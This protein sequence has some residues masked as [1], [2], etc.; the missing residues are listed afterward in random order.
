[1]PWS[2]SFWEWLAYS[3]VLSLLILAFGSGAVLLCRQ[4]VRR[5]RIIELCLAGSLLAPFLGMIPGYPQWSLA[6]RHFAPPQRAAVSPLPE[7]MP[8]AEPAALRPTVVLRKSAVVQQEPAIVP[9]QTPHLTPQTVVA[10]VDTAAPAWDLGSLLVGLYLLGIAVGVAW[11]LVGTAA[12]VRI[13]W[14]ARAAPPR[15]RQLLREI[16]GRHGDRVRLLTS[17]LAK[18]PFATVGL[19][20]QLAP[21]HGAWC[22]AVIVLPESFCDDEQAVRWA[23]AHEW[24]HIERRDFQAWFVAGLARMLFFYQPLVWWLRCQLRLCQDY[25]ADARASREASQPEDYAEFLTVRA[26]AG[27]LHPAM[28]GLGMGFSKSELYRRVAMLVENRPLESRAPR[29][30]TVLVTC[31]AMVL[32]GAAAALTASPQAAAQGEAAAKRESTPATAGVSSPAKTGSNPQSKATLLEKLGLALTSS[33]QENDAELGKIIK[34]K[35]YKFLNSFDAPDGVKRY[36]YRLTY[37]DGRQVGR[38]FYVPLDKVSSLEEYR[39]KEKQQRHQ[40]QNRIERALAAGRFRLLNLEAMQMHIC[41]D[42]ASGKTFMVQRIRRPDQSEIALPRADFGPLPSAVKQTSWQE[43]LQ[44]IRDGKRQLLNL[45]ATNNYTYEITA[46]DGTKEILQYGGTEPLEA[47]LKRSAD[48]FSYSGVFRRMTPSTPAKPGTTEDVMMGPRPQGNCSLSGKL[49]SASTGKS[50]A[51]ARMYLFYFGTHASIFTNTDK[52]GAFVFKDIPTGP[53]YLSSIHRAGYQDARYN[54]EDKPGTLPDFQ[55]KDGEQRSGI[56][57]KAEDA[58]RIVGQIRDEDGNVPSDTRA[59]SVS[60]WIKADDS[61]KYSPNSRGFVKPDGS[62]VIDGLG[63]APVYVMA[64]NW[65]AE[66]EGNG[67]PPIYAP[68]AFFRGE[69]RLVTFDKS[70]SV[71]GVNIT[72]R[73]TGGLALEGIVRDEKGTPIPETLVVVH[74]RD[75]LFDRVTTYSDAQGRYQLQGLGDGEVLVHVDAIHRGFVRTRIPLA[76]E[77]NTPK[78]RRDFILHRGASISGKL[79]DQDG[80]EWQ[81]GSSHGQAAITGDS[82]EPKEDGSWSGP[83]SKYG[84]QGVGEGSAVFYMSGDGD[85]ERND[86]VF[87]TTSTF[88]FPSLKPGHTLITFSPQAEGKKVVKILHG[89]RDIMESGL[90]TKPGQEIKDVTIVIGPK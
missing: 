85:Y 20:V 56:V 55:L 22:R 26:A 13:I 64:R 38:S 36:V 41:R 1:M 72:L 76:L 58:C 63:N 39:Q 24:T 19:A 50:I 34:D 59:I 90:D 16:A 74:H 49:V 84:I 89:G 15:C 53:F 88:V 54:P 48:P 8:V 14:T 37:P 70:R 83:R 43:H 78:V 42:A 71:E 10:P 30:W 51:R 3:A 57:L 32:I 46:E 12:L 25:V 33:E 80:K 47:I 27:L 75:M 68:S 69:A 11:W 87:P 73:K 79:V 44:A 60:A 31:I 86:M 17:R 21:H 18:Q 65:R 29:P 77:Q 4:P 35:K 52:E 61:D 40:R 45:E 9:P 5:L 2:E 28:T 67:Y 7:T 66:K 82:E 23:L 6:W 62:Y 81:I